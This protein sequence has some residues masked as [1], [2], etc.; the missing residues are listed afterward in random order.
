MSVDRTSIQ[1]AFD[2]QSEACLSLDGPFTARI[3]RLIG[4]RL[5]ESS[6]FG[7]RVW[8]WPRQS[9]LPD[10]MPLRCA[11]A[12]NFLVR[13]GKAPGLA[14]LYPPHE[15]AD[16][17]TL[18][19]A[20]E[21]TVAA[22]DPFMT[23]FLD[24][25]PQT[26]EVSRS[27]VLLGG[28]LQVARETQMPLALYEAGAS[29]GLNLLF[30]QYG[31]DLGEGREWGPRDSKVRIFSPWSGVSPPLDAAIEIASRDAVDLRPVDAREKN[32]RER[33]LAYI[34]PEQ[35]A[36]VARIEAALDVVAQSGLRV[37]AGD[38]LAWLR[39]KMAAAPKAGVCRVV[40]HS[41]FA[42]Y[43][44]LDVR[45]ALRAE[46]GAAGARAT[47]EAPFAWLAMEAAPDRL[48]CELT[49]AI[50]PGGKRRTLA[51]VDWHGKWAEWN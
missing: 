46:I 40:Y 16:D 32:D 9:L 1:K 31:F 30:D 13:M 24:S 33:M 7:R 12:L 10:L 45:H 15:G 51:R 8:S 39:A 11:A 35:L 48:G 25:P 41:V 14:R 36:R 27:A 44:P 28:F 47:P 20:I 18:W 49:L 34:W 37:E 5:G 50:W 2:R 21:A 38:A 17:E 43:L 4:A 26:N 22:H 3:C 6:A 42:Q 29:A 19:R 23:A